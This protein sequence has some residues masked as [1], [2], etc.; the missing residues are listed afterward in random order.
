[1]VEF[2]VTPGDEAYLMEINPRLWGSL[3]L[4]I[5]CGI[6]F[7]VG[8]LCLAT[9]RPL[10][11]Q[12][13]YRTGYFTRNIYRD[14]EWFKTN[15]KADHSDPLLLTKPIISSAFEWLRPLVGKESWDFFCWS[16]LRVVLGEIETIVGEHWAK[17]VNSVRRRS[18]R[19]YL[20][21]IQQPLMVRKLRGRKIDKVL[22]L[23]YGNI[24]RS[25]LAAALAARLM[26]NVSVS[27][28][29]FHTKTGRRSPDFVL[30]AANMLGVDLAEHRSNCVDA[31]MIGEA[32]LILIMDIRNYDLLKMGF[33]RALDKTLFL[34]MLLPSPQLEIKDPYDDPAS[35][36]A[37]ASR[38]ECA[39]EQ[40]S[41]FLR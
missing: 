41:A 30:A 34:G 12:P 33:P 29:G 15:W 16:D 22:I 5:D 35:M 4:A 3:A 32:E 37:V 27:S 26:P 2:K 9:E 28:A 21:H 8:L 25:P 11:P 31:K 40:M 10:P 6:D 7:P 18:R 20:R 38:M 39:I 14:I 13:K 19:L 24:C 36:P 1:M 17:C 23:C